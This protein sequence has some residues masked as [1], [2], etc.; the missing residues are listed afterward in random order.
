MQDF[1][2]LHVHTYYSILDGQ[3]NVKKLVDKY[4][5][6]RNNS[7]IGGFDFFDSLNFKKQRQKKRR[8]KIK[9]ILDKYWLSCVRL[10]AVWR[11]RQPWLTALLWKLSI[12]F[13]ASGIPKLLQSLSLKQLLPLRSGVTVAAV[14][15]RERYSEQ[16]LVALFS[17]KC[18]PEK[19]V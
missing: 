18:T 10:T 15:Y 13:F 7:L 4:N 19:G 1:V 17:T 6:P 16:R 2:H 9:K 5:P 11:D 8:E 14:A 12:V 3:E